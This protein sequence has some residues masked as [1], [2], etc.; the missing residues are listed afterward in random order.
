MWS[1]LLI[2]PEPVAPFILPALSSHNP[3]S[4]AIFCLS[5]G[6]PLHK[7]IVFL[8]SLESTGF[9]GDVVMSLSGEDNE[10]GVKDWLKSWTGRVRVVVYEVHW[11]C[12]DR[13]G[14]KVR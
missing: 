14:E 7:F 8:R 1:N 12:E 4:N 3:S 10:A 9:A 5:S 11:R 2:Y 13:K 6:Y